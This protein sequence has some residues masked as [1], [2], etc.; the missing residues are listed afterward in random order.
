MKKML[1]GRGTPRSEQILRASSSLIS[2][3]RGMALRRLS[4]G[5]CHQEW[6]LPSLSSSQPCLV[7]W[8]SRSLRFKGPAP[9]PHRTFP[10]RQ[11]HR[12]DS[13]PRLLGELPSKTSEAHRGLVPGHLH[14]V[15]LPPNR[16]KRLPLASQQR[17]SGSWWWLKGF[18][19]AYS[20]HRS[21][22][23]WIKRRHQPIVHA[24]GFLPMTLLFAG[25]VGP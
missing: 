22:A 2:Y 13:S 23:I 18:G 25:Q 12:P 10:R 6:L 9:F 17:C 7:R 21:N 11:G 16:S 19:V 5:C 3:W 14:Q 8:R 15:T 4:S 1:H 20:T 24:F